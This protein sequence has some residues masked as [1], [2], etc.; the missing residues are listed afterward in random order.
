MA[1]WCERRGFE[2]VIHERLFDA[3]SSGC[4]SSKGTPHLCPESKGDARY[5]RAA[6]FI[7]ILRGLWMQDKF[8][9]R[10]EHFSVED[11]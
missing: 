6:E 2:T 4:L 7:E 8:T 10:G 1:T 11:G 5:K 3:C 9:V